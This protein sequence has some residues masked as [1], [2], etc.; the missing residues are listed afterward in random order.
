MT[1]TTR[2]RRRPA[3]LRLV[4]LLFVA[5]LVTVVIA[6]IALGIRSDRLNDR[7]RPITRT[8]PGVTPTP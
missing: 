2:Q 8:L 1:T 7:E 6:F 5:V 4:V 3:G